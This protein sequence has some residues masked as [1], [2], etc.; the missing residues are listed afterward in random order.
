MASHR[1][2]SSRHRDGA[3]TWQR[4]AA[5][6]GRGGLLLATFLVTGI[7]AV[8]AFGPWGEN[9]N[10]SAY[11]DDPTLPVIS[12]G[13]DD[14]AAQLAVDPRPEL[15]SEPTSS[16]DVPRRSGSGRR[17]VFDISGQR[18]WI[19]GANDK[20]R[21]TYRV[22]GSRSENLSPG[23]Y[24]VFSR[25]RHAV[26]FGGHSTMEYFVR[27][28]RGKNSNIGFHDIPVD[29]SGKRIQS[30]DAL[31]TPQSAGCIRQRRS[32][33]KVMWRFAQMHTRV[34]VVA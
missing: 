24:R 31:G 2:T 28:A 20:V 15:Q 13:I 9:A 25:S 27:F 29:G 14:L 23:R 16:A 7:I 19:I 34:V 18:V 10:T 26:G 30:F 32:D 1:R 17:V 8:V 3:T 11:A 12:D 33:A 22:S 4:N 5:L 6:L 21:S